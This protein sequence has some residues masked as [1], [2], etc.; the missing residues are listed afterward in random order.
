MGDSNFVLALTRR[1]DALRSAPG[2]LFRDGGVREGGAGGDGDWGL[3]TEQATLRLNGGE[4][5]LRRF[6]A[7]A[8]R[9][10]SSGATRE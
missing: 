4:L 2:G 10:P 8:E 7:R 6:G 9:H 1:D 3:A 5:A